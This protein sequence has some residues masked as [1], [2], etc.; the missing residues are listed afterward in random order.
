MHKHR[1]LSRHTSVR[2]L[3]IVIIMVALTIGNCGFAFA[4]EMGDVSGNA[5]QSEVRAF[6]NDLNAEDPGDDPGED[7]TEEPVDIETAE[8][9]LSQDRFAYTGSEIAPDVTVSIGDEVLTA[10]TDYEVEYVNNVEPGTASV[11]VK[12]VGKYTGEKTVGF[13]IFITGWVNEGEDWYYYNDNGDMVTDGWAKD[14]SYWC[15]LDSSGKRV[16]DQW[17]TY[18]GESYYIKADGYM[19]AS[20]WEKYSRKWVWLEANGKMARS[21]WVNYKGDYYYLK[22]DGFMAVNEWAKSGTRW[23]WMDEAGKM[24]RN[25]W[26]KYSGNWYY[27]LSD[28]HMAT[29]KWIEDRKGWYWVDGNGKMVKSKWIKHSNHWYWLKSDGLMATNGWVKDDGS[30]Y[31]VDGNGKMVKSKWITYS[32]NSYYMK[33]NG[34]MATSEWQK[35]GGY[36]YW[37]NA[38]GA[39]SKDRWQKIKDCWYNFNSSGQLKTAPYVFVSI[40]E[41]MLYYCNNGSMVLSTSVVT[42]NLY[43]VN[44]STPKGTFYINGKATDMHLKGLEDDGV[45]EYDSFV[46]YWMPFIGGEFGLHDAD[47]R[48][49]FGGDI[50]KYNG[51]HGCVNMPVDAARRLFSM[52]TVGTMVHIQ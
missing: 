20:Q 48:W 3:L 30:W 2:T 41:Q 11:I 40:S 16:Y 49:Y 17:I 1:W 23:Y 14:G 31:W 38:S 46:R 24:V 36:W 29:N 32:G 22:D 43:P 39:M 6:G 25:K 47:W 26:I 10:G 15:W 8:V 33:S 13:T 12:G 19:A 21:Q 37:L 4:D 34:K 5:V 7:P 44:H 51:S 9:V 45:T 28:G 52:I 27:M 35:T 50:Y 42:G 18:R